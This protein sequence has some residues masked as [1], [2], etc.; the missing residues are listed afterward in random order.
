MKHLAFTE[1]LNK[2]VLILG[3]KYNQRDNVLQDVTQGGYPLTRVLITNTGENVKQVQQATKGGEPGREATGVKVTRISGALRKQT[4]EQLNGL[5]ERLFNRY[6][7]ELDLAK[8]DSSKQLKKVHADAYSLTL[9]F[10]DERKSL[11]T[12]AIIEKIKAILRHEMR[13]ERFEYE[14]ARASVR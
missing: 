6:F 7:D 9:N 1:L 4:P 2:D 14:Q 11:E 3:F 12:N 10:P 5:K 13:A 8:K